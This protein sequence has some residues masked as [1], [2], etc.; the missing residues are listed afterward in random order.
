LIHYDQQNQSRS[1]LGRRGAPM[2]RR[3]ALLSSRGRAND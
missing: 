1:L 2:K 3:P